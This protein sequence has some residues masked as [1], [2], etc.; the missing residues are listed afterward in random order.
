[1]RGKHDFFR[2]IAPAF[3]DRYQI[4][5]SIASDFVSLY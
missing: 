1:V 3:F 2:V 4:A 5:Q